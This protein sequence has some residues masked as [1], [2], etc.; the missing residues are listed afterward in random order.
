MDMQK[1][2]IYFEDISRMSKANKWDILFNT[3][4]Q[5]FHI[6]KHSYERPTKN[7]AIDWY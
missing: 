3:R 4:N 7:I 2:E 1:Y 6:L 5:K